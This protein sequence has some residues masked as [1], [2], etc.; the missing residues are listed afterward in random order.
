MAIQKQQI[1]IDLIKGADTKVN[2]MISDLNHD[3]VNVVFSGDLTA[4]K[5]NG[6]DLLATP[7]GNGLFSN[8]TKR[9]KDCIVQRAD[10]VYKYFENISDFRKISEISSVALID[11]KSPGDIIAYG[12]TCNMY[13]KTKAFGATGALFTNITGY[14]TLT[15][16]SGVIIQT[17]TIELGPYDT[18][19]TMSERYWDKWNKCVAIGDDFYISTVYNGINLAIHHYR[20][21]STFNSLQAVNLYVMD[22]A[23]G[24]PDGSFYTLKAFDMIPAETD[25]IVAIKGTAQKFIK[26]NS[27]FATTIATISESITSN[28]ELFFLGGSNVLLSAATLSGTVSN[29]RLRQYN[30]TTFSLVSD[31]S[32]AS[33][34]IG[35]GTTNTEAM[36][37]AIPQ[38]GTVVL[39]YSL[40]I[41][42]ATVKSSS[43]AFLPIK[44]G[45]MYSQDYSVFADGLIPISKIFLKN[46]KYYQQVMMCLGVTRSFHIIDVS[47]LS[48]ACIFNNTLT[49][50]IKFPV[51]NWAMSTNKLITSYSALSGTNNP[52]YWYPGYYAVQEVQIDGDNYIFGSFD[53][54]GVTK[55]ATLSFET[56]SN[57]QI[58]LSGKSFN[59]GALPLLFDGSNVVE[60]DFIGQPYLIF[61]GVVSAGA[62]SPLPADDGYTFIACYVWT[63]STG[64][65]Y[66][67]N[68]S[69]E[70]YAD[71]T[72]GLTVPASSCVSISVHTPVLTKKTNVECHIYI[73]NK[74]YQFFTLST[75]IPISDTP[76]QVILSNYSQNNEQ[77]YI[78]STGNVV[79]YP[80]NSMKSS[81]LY[82]N[83][84][85][86][87]KNG[88]ND[89]IYFSQPKEVTE[90]FTFNEETFKLKAYD[91]RGSFEDNLTALHAMD[92]RLFI[93]KDTS[94]LYTIGDGPAV[95]G[96][97]SDLIQPQLV[98]TDVGC[99]QPRSIVL[100]P[101][102]LMF[103]SDKGIYLLDRKLQVSYIGS[104]VE[105]FNS[106]TITSAI[107]LEKVNEIRFTTLEGEVLVYNYL[108]D[109]WSWFTNLPSVAAC[110]W[111]NTYTMLLSDGRVFTE[112]VN[113]KKIV[114][115]GM[116]TAIIQK[117]SSPWIRVQ[118]KQAW[119]KVYET[120]ILGVYKTQ[121]QVQV[122]FYYDYEN[123]ASDVY[124]LNP[125]AESQYNLNTRPT[126]ADIESG[127]ATDGVYQLLVDMVRKNCQS[128][129]VEIEDIPLDIENNTG[130]SFALSNLSVTFGAKKGPVKV[131]NSKTY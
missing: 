13:F 26:F 117:I 58:E 100:G 34:D 1:S 113:H 76:T 27:S 12:T 14:F 17:A 97:N 21:N 99:T 50:Q 129:R 18:T 9:G 121:H 96:S 75:I 24:R 11:E 7:S 126:N 63:D 46:N 19:N 45:V 6:Y 111:K 89:Y 35:H 10:G 122:S 41:I 83:R 91:K 44:K 105:K 59:S 42:S 5:M 119:E 3:M 88:D 8:I 127:V 15:D 98:T 22:N 73:K 84:V 65:I 131:P 110:I 72:G 128:F 86:Y 66:R 52:T 47:D 124:I 79:N 30:T 40:T 77:A 4:K 31:T 106:N 107:L 62:Y 118:D 130:E 116:S 33:R 114:Q 120:L 82:A 37:S 103:K 53:D 74:T 67:S 104:P 25:L 57:Q 93:F 102:G 80:A 109:A 94:V 16:K 70:L 71:V 29:L 87:I 81:A 101:N 28:I 125:L 51:V 38:S 20:F 68:M 85:F 23:S 69:N 39:A 90:G 64:V 32:I 60:N 108:S 49:N 123:Y 56:Y 2:P 95:D 92:G 115:S 54:F 48:P 55:K 61:N 43:V 36:W 78:E 112:S